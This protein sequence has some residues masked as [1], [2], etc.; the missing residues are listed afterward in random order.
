MTISDRKEDRETR[1]SYFT[2]SK[3][4][5]KQL[6]NGPPYRIQI[7]FENVGQ[8]TSTCLEGN[9]FFIDSSLQTKPESI[10]ALSV[11][12]DI[13]PN[14][15]TPWYYDELNLPKDMPKKY[16]VALIK[17]YDPILKKEFDQKFFMKWDGIQNGFTHP[18]FTHTNK[19]E[20]ERIENYLKTKNF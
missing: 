7:T 3:P 12:N 10:I 20:R 11:A 18:D 1:R 5:I 17:Y 15:P 8:H 14:I 13:P 19:A 6:S 4:G 16:I 9:I 2:I